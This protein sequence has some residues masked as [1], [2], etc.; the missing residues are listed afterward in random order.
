MGTPLWLSICLAV[1]SSVISIWVA[2]NSSAA[3]NARKQLAIL[4]DKLRHETTLTV[5]IERRFARDQPVIVEFLLFN[6]NSSN[7]YI[8]GAFLDGNTPLD[9]ESL[10]SNLINSALKPAECTPLIQFVD[11]SKYAGNSKNHVDLNS[12]G[13]IEFFIFLASDPDHMHSQLLHFDHGKFRIEDGRRL[14]LGEFLSFLKAG[15][16]A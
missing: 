11:L 5:A 3:K 15:G 10:T 6:L 4:E 7:I 8:S 14:T 2:T 16:H 12:R 9:L 13:S 1:A